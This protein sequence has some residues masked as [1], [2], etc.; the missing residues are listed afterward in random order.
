MKRQITALA[1]LA[2]LPACMT[3]Q[4][5]N[6]SPFTDDDIHFEG[7]ASK[8]NALVVLQAYNR[9]TEQWMAAGAYTWSSSSK[10]TF[11]DR[12]LYQWKLD[13]A[14]GEGLNPADYREC[15]WDADCNAP[16]GGTVRLRTYEPWGHAK[17]MYTFRPGGLDCTI[18]RVIQQF[19]SLEAAYYNCHPDGVQNEITVNMIESEYPF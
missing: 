18:Q 1:V 17:A 16:F 5:P 13:W 10:L 11:G 19:E 12:D 14:M 2:V 3:T 15:F 7:W 9:N 8:P 4:S 6:I